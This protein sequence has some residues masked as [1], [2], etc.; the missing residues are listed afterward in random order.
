MKVKSATNTQLIVPDRIRRSRRK[1]IALIMELDGTLEVRAPRQMTDKQVLDYVQSKASWIRKRQA[2]VLAV[3][4]PHHYQQGEEFHYLGKLYPLR[5][6]AK[7]RKSVHFTGTSIDLKASVQPEAAVWVEGWYRSQAREH[8]TGRLEYFAHR[9]GFFYENLRI[10]SAR[11][12]WGSCNAQRKS[13]NFTWRLVMAPPDIVD[14]VVV[15]ELCHLRHAN[16]SAA[17][18]AEVEGIMPDYKQRRKWLK[19]NGVKLRL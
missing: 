17:F 13:L 3:P 5:Y 9:Y 6:V 8:L 19:D 16:H 14:Y 1:T 18:W 15:H 10:N 2:A 4:P 12:R 11:T 7:Q